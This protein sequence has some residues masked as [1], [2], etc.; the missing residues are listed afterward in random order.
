M[1]PRIPRLLYV[2]SVSNAPGPLTTLGTHGR[3]P[4][5]SG[6]AVLGCQVQISILPF[7]GQ[8]FALASRGRLF[9]PFKG[10]GLISICS[11]YCYVQAL[12][13]RY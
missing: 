11:L 1:A 3:L 9:W 13:L 10:L 4:T 2:N 7:I 12:L 5:V 6:H 8:A